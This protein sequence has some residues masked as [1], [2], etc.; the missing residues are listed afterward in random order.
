MQSLGWGIVVG[1]GDSAHLSVL[2]S[3]GKLDGVQPQI[4][5]AQ[6]KSQ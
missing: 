2:L 1:R 3:A 5:Q 4:S 6:T